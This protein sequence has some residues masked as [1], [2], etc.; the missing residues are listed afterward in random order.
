MKRIFFVFSLTAAIAAAGL[1]IY[2][3][4]FPAEGY[5]H[6]DCTDTLLWAQ[7]SYDSGKLFSED[8]YYAALLPFGTSLFMLPFIPVFGISM[9][10]HVIGMV[11]FAVC[12]MAALMF[13]LR[14]LRFNWTWTLSVTSLFL[15]LMSSS[16]KLREIFWGHTIY[17]SLGLLFCFVGGGLILR[18]L[19]IIDKPGAG[20]AKKY[21]L[22]A[23]FAAFTALTAFNGLQSLVIYIAPVLFCLAAYCF[24]DS[25]HPFFGAQNI[26]YFV[27]IAITAASAGAGMLVCALLR[28][29]VYS[30]YL[31]GYSIFSALDQWVDNILSF[32]KMWFSLLGVQVA[33]GDYLLAFDAVADML[34]TAV[35]TVLLIVPVA[36]LFEYKKIKD[37]RLKLLIW[38]CWGVIIAI[39]LGFVVGVI[40]NAN[41]RLTP[42]LGATALLSMAM[43]RYWISRRTPMGVRFSVAVLA[44]LTAGGL[45]SAGTIALMPADYGRDND[46]HVLARTLEENDLTYGYATFWYSQAITVISDSQ[47]KVRNVKIEPSTGCEKYIY[48]SERSW[49]DAQPGQENYFLLLTRSELATLESS[50]NGRSLIKFAQKTI[51]QSGYTILVFDRNLF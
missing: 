19:D 22:P 37:N 21:I 16:D 36:S 46:L 48:Q 7:A 50:I 24:F 23:V 26:R 4:V 33:K 30:G 17:Y 35:G 18:W 5:F 9:T 2:Y 11:I 45:V 42:M 41:W 49:F 32:P 38:L 51:Q 47:V 8:F 12:F 39:M 13:F 15:M 27:L 10:T 6:S 28:G 20:T 31:S 14:S 34:R 29:N 1:V 40:G 44:V 25:E 43:A 3:T